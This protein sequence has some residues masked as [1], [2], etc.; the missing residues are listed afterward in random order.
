MLSL[1]HVTI[2][3]RH[4]ILSDCSYEFH[5][6]TLYGLVATNGSGK[7]TLFRAL[8]GLLSLD[9]GEIRY[10]ALPLGKRSIFYFE[11]I[12]WF[13]PSLSGMD[14]IN[15]VKNEWQSQVDVHSYLDSFKMEDYV[16]LPIRTY[17]LGMKQRLLIVLYL[18][19]GAKIL[20]M[21][22]M[23]NGLD[24]ESRFIFFLYL[25]ELKK[26]KCTVLLSSHYIEDIQEHCDQV[27]T[28]LDGRLEV[29]H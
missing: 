1:K 5:E 10:E 28:M 8:S 21:D 23:T 19:S 22:E 24:E 20:L 18:I 4:T 14:Y 7:T 15:F 11:T 3:T 26:E 13:D 25:K 27:L 6:G 29:V 2:T 16:K 12:E 9:K 17:S